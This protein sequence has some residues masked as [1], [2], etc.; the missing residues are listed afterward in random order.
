MNCARIYN[1]SMASLSSVILNN[2]IA[3]IEVLKGCLESDLR[4]Q[5]SLELHETDVLNGFFIYSLLLDHAE[6][7]SVLCL[8][9]NSPSHRHRLKP[10]LQARNARMEGFGQEE[11]THACNLCYIV[12]LDDNGD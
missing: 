3:H 1:V 4:W 12:F 2:P 6:Q 11:Y 5:T 9:H 7:K 8:D 10:A